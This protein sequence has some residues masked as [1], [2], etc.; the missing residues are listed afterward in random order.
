MAET[1]GGGELRTL[2]VPGAALATGVGSLMLPGLAVVSLGLTFYVSMPFLVSALQH[3]RDWK[4]VKNDHAKLAVVYAAAGYGAIGVAAVPYFFT[5]LVRL[6]IA[7]TEDR[8]KADLTSLFLRQRSTA[9]VVHDGTEVEVP[10][11]TIRAGD[12]VSVRAAETIP[13]DGV[14]IAGAARVDQHLLTGEWQPIDRGPGDAVFAET[15]VASGHLRIRVTKAGAETT[16]RQIGRLLLK[17]ADYKETLETRGEVYVIRLAP[18]MLGAGLVTLPILGPYGAAGIMHSFPGTAYRV[19]VPIAVLRTLSRCSRRGI[20]VKDGR[21][22]EVLPKVTVVVFDKTGT[23]TEDRPEVAAIHGMAAFAPEESLRLAATAEGRQAH[24]L[25]AALREEAARR[26]LPVSDVAVTTAV[27]G[28]GVR[29]HGP[30]GVVSVGSARFMEAEAIPMPPE[31]LA[32][33]TAIAARGHSAVWVGLDG[34]LVGCIEIRPVVRPEASAVVATLRGR[35]LRTLIISGD[36][37]APTRT[38]ADRLGIDEYHARTLLADKAR[39]VETLQ[40]QGEVVCF[41]GDGI[42]DAIALRQAQVSVSLRGAATV[43]TDT[44]HVVLMTPDL[45]RLVDVFDIVSAYDENTRLARDGS[46]VPSAVSMGS[47]ALLGTGVLTATL[48]NHVSI[49]GGMAVALQPP[50]RSPARTARRLAPP[51]RPPTMPG[52]AP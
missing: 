14:V 37:E 46:L 19:V 24:P 11:A 21:L 43:A 51:D 6:L 41:V 23:L 8:S 32:L 5:R 29:S 15:L 9:W 7:R 3:L 30:D 34:A 33:H 48:M 38:L 18:Y 27:V 49:W 31:A 47:A 39:L 22:L 44:A 26:A 40:E 45:R 35:G 36:E 28:L 10:Y 2:A 42:N 12:I 25:A 17:T 20:L 50:R 1:D 4:R 13:V 52:A 16:A